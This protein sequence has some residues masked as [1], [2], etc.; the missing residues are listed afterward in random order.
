M[1]P[2]HRRLVQLAKR[3]VCRK[4][5]LQFGAAPGA[6]DLQVEMN[7]WMLGNGILIG[8]C[9]ISLVISALVIL[10]QTWLKLERHVI[11]VGCSVDV[12]RMKFTGFNPAAGPLC[13][14]SVIFPGVSPV[15]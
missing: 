8:S 1:N 3:E 12:H 13:S 5:H 2:P 14:N 15:V 10:G 11:H 4:Q 9:L 6:P 7:Y